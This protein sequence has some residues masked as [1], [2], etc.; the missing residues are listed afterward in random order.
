MGALFNFLSSISG[1]VLWFFFDAVSNYA[2]A[3]TLF[4]LVLNLIMIPMTIKR[5]K[6]SAKTAR[7][8][9]KQQELKKKYE[10]NPKKYNEE[11]A[12]LYEKEG[13]NP[14]GG[15]L[16]MLLPLIIF[17][18]IYGTVSNPLDNTLHIPHE[19]TTAAIEVL[20]T[21]PEFEGKIPKR[22][23]QLYLVRH[24]SSVKDKLTMF[25]SEELADIEEYSSGFNFMGLDLL[26]TPKES[27]FSSM[28]WIIP[29]L[30]FVSSALAMYIGQKAT[31]AQN[32]AVGCSK[33]SYYLPFIFTAYVAYTI[34]AAVGTYWIVNSLLGLVQTLVLNKF[35]NT[36]TINAHDEAARFALLK[37]QESEIEAK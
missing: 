8:S 20:N 21:T 35:Y 36:Y 13:V 12:L 34:P 3:I 22:Y 6:A 37:V 26:D 11:A 5:Q 27:N 1:Y 4:T 17:M 23:E 19:K 30:C 28:L 2:L 7:I 24:F 9:M 29:V 16:T 32:M 33:Y 14:V 18:G 10:K 31:G 15:C 25:N